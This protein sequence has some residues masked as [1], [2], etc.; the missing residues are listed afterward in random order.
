M[1]QTTAIPDVCAYDGR[2]ID[3]MTLEDSLREF[4]TPMCEDCYCESVDDA[5]CPHD[6][7]YPMFLTRGWVTGDTTW[8]CPTCKRHYV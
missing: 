1:A 2:A 3:P 6:G 5:T 4:D 8:C 7:T